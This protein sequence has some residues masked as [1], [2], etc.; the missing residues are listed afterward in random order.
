MK[1]S[2]AKHSPPGLPPLASTQLPH[3]VAIFRASGF[4]I[5]FRRPHTFWEF[6]G[7]CEGTLA[8]LVVSQFGYRRQSG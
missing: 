3:G 2:R 7:V 8:Q 1:D 4:P 5:P 6:S